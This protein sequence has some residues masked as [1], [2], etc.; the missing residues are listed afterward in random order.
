MT[1]T[2]ETPTTEML[3]AYFNDLAHL[4]TSLEHLWFWAGIAAYAFLSSQ[5]S[6][7]W[8]EQHGFETIND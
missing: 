6:S 1:P 7:K 4:D 8:R 3:N 2:T 5:G